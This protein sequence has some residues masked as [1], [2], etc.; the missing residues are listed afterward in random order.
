MI[1][2]IL[3]TYGII[4]CWWCY[5]WIRRNFI[6]VIRNNAQ[7]CKNILFILLFVIV[8][9]IFFRLLNVLRERKTIDLNNIPFEF[10]W[11]ILVLFVIFAYSIRRLLVYYFKFIWFRLHYFLLSPYNLPRVSKI[12]SNIFLKLIYNPLIFSYKYLTFLNVFFT[13]GLLLF[14]LFDL[15]F[16]NYILDISLLYLRYYSLFK[17]IYVVSKFVYEKQILILDYYNYN[18]LYTL[19]IDHPFQSIMDPKHRKIMGEAML[20]KR[21]IIEESIIFFPRKMDYTDNAYYRYI[22]NSMK[23]ESVKMY[24]S[25]GDFLKQE[26]KNSKI[27]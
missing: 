4:M 24:S 26:K 2:S 14:F 8:F 18:I 27:K 16:N 10:K 15:I 9:V 7:I 13:S 12:Y 23:I 20:Y 22:N 6:F 17:L 11:Y 19:D 25:F 1:I 3:I 21:G 5:G